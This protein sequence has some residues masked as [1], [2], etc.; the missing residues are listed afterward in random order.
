MAEAAQKKNASKINKNK[1]SMDA[2]SNR[3]KPPA[4]IGQSGGDLFNKSRRVTR[5]GGNSMKP[6]FP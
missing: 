3:H 6:P 5:T 2:Y 1:A 4:F